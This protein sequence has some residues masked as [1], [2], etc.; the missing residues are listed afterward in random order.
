MLSMSTTFAV[1]IGV[2]FF[3]AAGLI[4][5]LARFIPMREE[6]MHKALRYARNKADKQKY[7]EAVKRLYRAGRQVGWDYQKYLEMKKVNKMASIKDT[8]GVLVKFARLVRVLPKNNFPWVAEAMFTLGGLYK[9]Q[10]KTKKQVRLYT[11]LRNFITEYGADLNRVARANLL[12]R[13]SAEEAVIDLA[14]ENYRSALGMEAAF[15]LHN[16]EKAYVGGGESAVSELLPYAGTEVLHAALR[17][18]GRYDDRHEVYRI[19]QNAIVDNGARIDLARVSRELDDFLKG[20]K[21]GTDLE[22]EM[23]RLMIQKV[24]EKAGQKKIEEDEEGPDE[25]GVIH[26]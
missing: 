5:V 22:R 18:L 19:V 11:D 16:V 20:R 4:V 17:G 1:L 2:I 21:T 24:L 6:T 9:V 7:D 3:V 23:A 13:I 15:F 14:R 12:A 8:E 10:G 26:L 25:G